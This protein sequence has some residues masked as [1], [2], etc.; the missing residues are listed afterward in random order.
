MS[1]KMNVTELVE[2]LAE[3]HGIKREE[4][5]NFVKEFFSLIEEALEKDKY[6][7]IKG[8]GTFKLIDVDSRESINV[9]TG[10][11]FEIQEHS[12]VSFTPDAALKTL[13]NKPFEHF[14]PVLLNEHTVLEEAPAEEVGEEKK[15]VLS[16]NDG[17]DTG[18]VQAKG[19]K[20][21]ENMKYFIL[22]V[23][24]VILLCGTVIAF[25]YVPGLLGREQSSP[26]PASMEEVQE[27]DGKSDALQLPGQTEDVLQQD[28]PSAT[29]MQE[30]VVESPSATS[31]SAE[32]EI[33]G[34]ETT[35]TIKQGETLTKVA[36]RFY[37]TKALWPYIVKHNREIIKNP[38]NVP[39]G[40]TIKIPK[41][42]K[43]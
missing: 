27:A 32:Y 24:L 28:A 13:I 25:L 39:Y 30:Q 36:L 6:I 34:T 17:Q 10:E 20:E 1:Q 41:L 33:V 4:A 3:K 22:I 26:A 35:Y 38:D 23:L 21:S 7:K 37:G 9:N 12:K 11:R 5:E 18:P 19:K 31:G 2:A 43:K 16:G 40:T 14:E 42:V 29:D 8:L 15:E